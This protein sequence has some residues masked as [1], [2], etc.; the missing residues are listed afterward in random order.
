VIPPGKSATV[1]INALKAGE[2]KFYDE[3]NEATARGKVVVR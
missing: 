1:T 3:F 2:Y